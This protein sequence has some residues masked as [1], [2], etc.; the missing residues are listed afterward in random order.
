MTRSELTNLFIRKTELFNSE[1]LL[2]S[3]KESYSVATESGFPE[4]LERNIFELEQ[5]IARERAAIARDRETALQTLKLIEDDAGRV[6]AMLHYLEGMPWDVAA[7]L[8][9]YISGNALRAAAY[10]GMN[11][12]KIAK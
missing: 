3:L 7:A 6:G 2:A 4:N 8:L 11:A 1:Q 9:R 10:R 5:K 12:A